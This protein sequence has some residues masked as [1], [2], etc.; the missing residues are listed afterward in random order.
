MQVVDNKRILFIATNIPTTK[1]KSNKV[2]MTIA[3]KLSESFGVSILHPSEVVPFPLNLLKKYANISDSKP[4]CDDGITVTPF[5]YMRLPGRRLSFL[6]LPFF[7][8]KIKK[9]LAV[10]EMP[11]LTHSHYVMPDGYF[12]YMMKRQ[13]GIPYVIS[14]RDSDIKF[15][16]LDD[17]RKVKKMTIEVLKNADKVV[18]HNV[19]HQAFLRLY[20]IDSEVVSHG[21]EK[22]FLQEKEEMTAKEEVM[23]TVVSEFI[24]RKNLDWIIK[25]VKSYSGDKC[26]KLNVIGKGELADD[27][28]NLAKD[29][30]NISFLGQMSH[31]DVGRWL[32]VSD[33]FALP[34]YHETLGLVYLEAAAKENA[35]IAMK[36]TGVWGNYQDGE[37]ML[38][39]D[40]YQSFERLLHNLIDDDDKRISLSEKA[41]ERTRSEY[42]WN[43]SIEKY[44][45]IYENVSK[46]SEIQ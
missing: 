45:K 24:K 5:K 37:E 6:L 44:K 23:V 33:I 1:R 43:V 34:S 7:K 14:F 17:K 31:D 46:L 16:E 9:Y 32:H 35:V 13:Y 41:F 42:T 19:A 11:C 38:F 28:K 15:L 36:Y 18:V 27:L 10:G 8:N 22:F 12:S 2:V 29:C 26:L 30:K 25:A 39:C 20:G 3:H 40:D 21:I 4:W